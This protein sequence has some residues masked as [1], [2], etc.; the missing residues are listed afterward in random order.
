M[1][2]TFNEIKFRANAGP[3]RQSWQIWN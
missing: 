2:P 3:T 1:I